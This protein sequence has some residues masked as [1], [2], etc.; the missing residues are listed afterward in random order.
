MHRT[1]IR[2]SDRS[3]NTRIHRLQNGPLHHIQMVLM[4]RH[5]VVQT[6]SPMKISNDSSTKRLFVS[7]TKVQKQRPQDIQ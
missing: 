2:K 1:Q 3:R 4:H 6:A 7:L 5:Q